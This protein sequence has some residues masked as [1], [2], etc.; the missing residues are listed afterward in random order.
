[1]GSH[2]AVLPIGAL[3]LNLYD[4]PPKA[5]VQQHDTT[6]FSVR[7]N[8]LSIAR[9]RSSELVAYLAIWRQE[10]ESC[11]CSC[12][13]AGIRSYSSLDLE[14]RHMKNCFSLG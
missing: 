7:V 1:M 6:G 13:L 10:G 3:S 14:L 8:T 2:N 11:T 9:L 4:R 5:L 12:A